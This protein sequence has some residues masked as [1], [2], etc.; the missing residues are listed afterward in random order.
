MHGQWQRCYGS[1]FMRYLS[2]ILF[3]LQIPPTRYLKAELQANNKKKKLA[4]LTNIHE[5][6]DKIHIYLLIA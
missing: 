1:A 2:K 3:V 5:C 4:M 6:L